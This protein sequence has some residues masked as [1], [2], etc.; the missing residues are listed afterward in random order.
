MIRDHERY[1][2]PKPD[3]IPW[4]EMAR[5]AEQVMKELYAAVQETGYAECARRA[6]R[7]AGARKV[8]GAAARPGSPAPQSPSR[9][10]DWCPVPP[11]TTIAPDLETPALQPPVYDAARG[12]SSR[13]PTSRAPELLAL[14]DLAARMKRRRV[15]R[16]AAR[17]Q[18]ARDDLRQELD[19]HPRLLR[20]R[21]L[22][23]RRARA[24][25]LVARHPARP[26][27]ADPRH[28]ARAL[29][30]PRRHHDPHLRSRRR[31]GAGAL[32]DRSRSSTA[33]P[34]CCT[35]ARCSPTS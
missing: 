23:A 22:P 21:R 31:R 3:T 25:P 18:D 33:S 1:I 26:R 10:R 15:P 5:R 16:A 29:A 32:R 14:F 7:Q 6:R 24:L 13:S 34:T 9:A 30:L 2:N 11:P 19:P 28:R 8:V 35:P 12:T 20:G 4:E 27:R 17:R